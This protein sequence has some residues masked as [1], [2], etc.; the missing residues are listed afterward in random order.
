[1]YDVFGENVHYKEVTRKETDVKKNVKKCH[2]SCAGPHMLQQRMAGTRK[3]S[4]GRK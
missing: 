2:F 3:L 1:M 4:K